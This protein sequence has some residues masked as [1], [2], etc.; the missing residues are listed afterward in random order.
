MVLYPDSTYILLVHHVSPVVIFDRFGIACA[1]HYV[2]YPNNAFDHI[3]IYVSTVLVPNTAHSEECPK[4]ILQ[5]KDVPK[6]F[7]EGLCCMAG[8]E[9]Q[10]R[11][12]RQEQDSFS[13]HG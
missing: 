3:E 2:P 4:D 11:I 12:L 7:L 8:T 1:P 5:P 9:L 6:T 13:Q 10:F